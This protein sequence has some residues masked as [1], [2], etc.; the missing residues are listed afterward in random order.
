MFWWQMYV[1]CI[2]IHLQYM[3]SWLGNKNCKN[4]GQQRCGA[5]MSLYSRARSLM[6]I[7]TNIVFTRSQKA[8]CNC[9]LRASNQAW[10]VV[11]FSTYSKKE[12]FL[13]WRANE[14]DNV[15][16]T[17]VSHGDPIEDFQNLFDQ[18]VVNERPFKQSWQINDGWR[19]RCDIT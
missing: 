18:T 3:R 1:K 12:L 5:K 11:D 4:E 14:S 8:G 15:F 6:V 9:D 10:C 16:N 13:V 2:W 17:E 7:L 19:C